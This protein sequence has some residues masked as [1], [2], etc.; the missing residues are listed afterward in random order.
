VTPVVVFDS[1]WKRFRRGERHDSLRDLVPAVAKRLWHRTPGTDTLRQSDFW[2]LRDVSFAVQRGEAFGIL[3]PNGAGKST[4]L[5]LL[6][7]ILKPDRGRSAL[8]GRAGALIEVAAGFHPDLTGRENVYLQGA[9]MGM[10]RREIN[11]KLPD[12]IDFAGLGD[13][14]DTPVKRFSSG[15]NARLGFSIAAHLDPEILIIDEVL[16][17]GDYAFQQKCQE[18]MQ[19]FKQ[20]GV[21][22]VFVSHNMFA[23][24]QLCD[25]ALLLSAGEPQ[26]VGTPEDAIQRYRTLLSSASARQT[27]GHLAV[28]LRYDGIQSAS[29]DVVHV[30]P[31]AMLEIEA[32]AS[33]REH[34]RQAVVGVQIWSVARN[35]SVYDATTD[36]VGLPPCDIEPGTSI[37]VQ[38]SLDLHLGRGVYEVVMHVYDLVRQGFVAH[39]RSV[40]TFVVDDVR[41]QDHAIANLYLRAKMASSAGAQQSHAGTQESQVL[42]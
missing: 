22:I 32:T 34:V 17:V 13:F 26:F 3:G 12:I 1:V 29:T 6:T 19:Q 40:G 2:A 39:P 5:K 28:V 33:F 16:A 27:D 41:A 35:L 20:R 8:H 10:R 25:R 7:R 31:G 36:L 18:R 30:T 21:A 4:I 9:V 24:T 14:I 38:M 42:V 11:E 37:N 23:L 15:M